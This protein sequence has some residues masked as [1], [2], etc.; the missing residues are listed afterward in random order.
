MSSLEVE[1]V[2]GR[3]HQIRVHLSHIGHP[4]IGDGKYGTNAVNRP[5]RAKQQALWAYKLKFDFT[6]S[7][8]VLIGLL[9][10]KKPAWRL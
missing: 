1:L 9:E 8:G 7:K 10:W 2:T 5:L 3:T 4:I 6:D